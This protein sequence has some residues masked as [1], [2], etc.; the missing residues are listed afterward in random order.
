MTVSLDPIINAEL[1]MCCASEFDGI[2]PL[3]LTADFGAKVDTNFDVAA[4]TISKGM[5][6]G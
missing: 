6:L 4:Q 2:E 3:S 5:N 1:D